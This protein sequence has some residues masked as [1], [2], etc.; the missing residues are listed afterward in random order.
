M[1]LNEVLREIEAE[2]YQ[3]HI[4]EGSFWA[5]VAKG[6]MGLGLSRKWKRGKKT[7][8]QDDRRS[9]SFEN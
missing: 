8:P 5:M 4:R 6:M 7:D 1:K 3:P 9:W 2:R